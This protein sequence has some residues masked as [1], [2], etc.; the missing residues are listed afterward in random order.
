MRVDNR[1]RLVW[2]APP[3][4]GCC[5]AGVPG[6]GADGCA[7]FPPQPGLAESSNAKANGKARQILTRLSIGLSMQ[8]VAIKS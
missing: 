8:P 5:A 4:A 6:A 1:L 2:P 7:V 3:L